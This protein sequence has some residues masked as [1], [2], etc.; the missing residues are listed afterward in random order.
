MKCDTCYIPN[1]RRFY[2]DKS[3]QSI[4]NSDWTANQ[5]FVELYIFLHEY[6]NLKV[7]AQMENKNFIS[8][9]FVC[10]LPIFIIPLFFPLYVVN[11]Y[12]PSPFSVSTWLFILVLLFWHFFLW[13]FFLELKKNILKTV[14]YLF[15]KISDSCS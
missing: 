13:L 12:Y 6:N 14:L 15:I 7:T 1:E 8:D 5:N 10:F 2:M 3:T 4:M 11:R 9:V